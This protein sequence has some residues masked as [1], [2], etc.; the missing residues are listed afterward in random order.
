M[1]FNKKSSLLENLNFMIFGF[2]GFL[3]IV[4]LLI[5]AS[6]AMKKKMTNKNQK[7]L[8]KYKMKLKQLILNGIHESINNGAIPL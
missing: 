2:V 7:K 3:I 8:K 5:F 1:G 6:I 4:I